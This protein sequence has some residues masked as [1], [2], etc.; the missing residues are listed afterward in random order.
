MKLSCL[1]CWL[2][3]GCAVLGDAVGTLRRLRNAA[4]AAPGEEYAGEAD[5]SDQLSCKIY[6]TEETCNRPKEAMSCEWSAVWSKCEKKEEPKYKEPTREDC[7]NTVDMADCK[8]MYG[9]MYDGM[10]GKCHATPAICAQIE[11]GEERSPPSPLECLP[12]L[13]KVKPDGAC[14][15]ICK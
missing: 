2:A 3:L 8:A 1:A 15:F 7:E 14:C 5:L 12:P 4:K 10:T 13:E 9:C 11:C 6:D